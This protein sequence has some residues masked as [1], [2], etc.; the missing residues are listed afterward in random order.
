MPVRGRPIALADLV[1]H[2]SGLPRLPKGFLRIALRERAN[3]YSS[4]TVEQL[5][6]AIAATRPRRD[7]GRKVRYSNYGAGLL[8][9][10]LE[11][12]TG[13]SYD[14]LV[15][16][17]I[18]AP[19]GMA[20]TSIAVPEQK[21]ERFA[22]GHSRRGKP[23]SHWDLPSLAGAGALRSTVADL[24]RFLDAQTGDAPPGLGEA[25][26]ETQKPR[27]TRGAL[28]VGLGWFSLPIKGLDRRVVW[29]DGGT[30]GFRSVAGFVEGGETAVVVLSNSAR[31]VDQTG[32]D[33]ARSL[34]T[35]AAPVRPSD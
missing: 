6:T 24:M 29:H 1:S 21:R 30:G 25:M 8:G 18:T 10:V 28:S 31:P 14:A 11:L 12:R 16:E 27:A 2:T 15:T 26:R 9:H 17:R 19:L 35:G 22:Q 34:S 3:P 5:H 13:K 20:D 23:V 33:I 32:L 7:P 4:Y